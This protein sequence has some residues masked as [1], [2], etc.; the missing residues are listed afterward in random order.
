M[1]EVVWIDAKKL[2]SFLK[3][4]AATFELHSDQIFVS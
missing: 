4:E 3:R 1:L 2:C